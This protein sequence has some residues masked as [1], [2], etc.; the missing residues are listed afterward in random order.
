MTHP[1]SR[2]MFL[3]GSATTLAGV[4]LA[5]C[6]GDADK[7]KEIAVSEVPVGDFIL[8]QPTA[9]EYKAY[10]AACTHQRAK[11]TKVDGSH[12]ICP[13]HGSVFDITDGSVVSGLARDPL[14]AATVEVT[15]DTATVTS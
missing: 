6:G 7:A 1:C 9:G 14:K 5:A 12:V 2:R 13:A 4:V 10:S 3:L 11:I 8:A 15:G